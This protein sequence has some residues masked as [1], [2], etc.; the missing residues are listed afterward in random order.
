MMITAIC[1]VIDIKILSNSL[2]MYTFE[3]DKYTPWE[4]GMF[5]H[6]N[7]LDSN[8]NNDW[9]N[10][11]PFSFAS[12]GSNITK[13]IVRKTGKYTSQM[14]RD[15]EI[16]KSFHIKYA[17]GDF[18]LNTPTDKVMIAGG[19]GIAP[20]LSYL[21]WIKVTNLRNFNYLFH[22]VKL[23]SESVSHMIDEFPVN[24]DV[25][26]YVTQE[27]SKNHKSRRISITDILEKVNNKEY[28]EYYL[29]G[30]FDFINDFSTELRNAGCTK[31]YY[32]YWN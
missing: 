19:S 11:R 17:F 14:F 31:I 7:I 1:T 16:G 21:D 27:I 28:F 3:M 25:D 29:C 4:P 9:S 10:S 23:E 6:V 20:F 32:E 22:S 8:F 18:F 24:C 2:R 15:L 13:L 26:I 5:M 12:F 30:S